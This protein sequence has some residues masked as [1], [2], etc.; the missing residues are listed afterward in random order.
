[1]GRCNCRSWGGVIVVQHEDEADQVRGWVEV[2]PRA[3]EV[4]P[5]DIPARHRELFLDAI[6]ET[7]EADGV[8]VPEEREAFQLLEELMR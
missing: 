3:D 6:R 5:T 1:M 4:D 7:I 8:I 2:P